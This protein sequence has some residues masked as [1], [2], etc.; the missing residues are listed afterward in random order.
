MS[1]PRADTIAAILMVLYSLIGA[2]DAFST[3]AQGAPFKQRVDALQAAQ[4]E[5]YKKA[6]SALGP[7]RVSALDRL[8]AL[9]QKRRAG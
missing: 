3:L 6:R 9:E 1:R 2:I 5:N 4:K 8:I 7:N